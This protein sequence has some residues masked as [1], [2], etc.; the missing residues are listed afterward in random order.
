[1]DTICYRQF[2]IEQ[3][4]EFASAMNHAFRLRSEKDSHIPFD[5]ISPNT[6]QEELLLEN[7]CA[8]VIYDH[9]ALVGGMFLSCDTEGG[10]KTAKI[11]HLFTHPSFQ[12]KGIAKQLM[13]QAEKYA[14]ESGCSLMRLNV[15]HIV[16]PAISL[17][18]NFGY[19]PISIYACEPG[20]FHFISMIKSLPPYRFPESKRRFTL[21]R[22]KLKFYFLFRSDSTPR[23][24]QKKLFKFLRK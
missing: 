14:I 10:I 8:L 23:F 1:M 13:L 6:L 18:N 2:N 17:Y 22:S 24:Y 7:R 4:S 21:F 3:A 20:T 15:G 11:Y 16:Q 5:T 19:K 12:G 9:Y